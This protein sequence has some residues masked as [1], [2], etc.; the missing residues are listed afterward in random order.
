M[1]TVRTVGA[2]SHWQAAMTSVPNLTYPSMHLLLQN[3]SEAEALIST[4]TM[5]DYSSIFC[6]PTCTF[7][8]HCLR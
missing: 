2:M 6:Q 3:S 4:L 1:S 5:H 7:H 8:V